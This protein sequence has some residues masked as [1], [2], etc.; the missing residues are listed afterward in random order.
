MWTLCVRNRS[1]VSLKSLLL[2]SNF[3]IFKSIQVLWHN[4][5]TTHLDKIEIRNQESESEIIICPGTGEFGPAMVRFVNGVWK[6]R[7]KPKEL[8]KKNS[9]VI[10]ICRSALFLWLH[11]IFCWMDKNTWAHSAKLL[12]LRGTG[13]VH[14]ITLVGFVRMKSEHWNICS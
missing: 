5:V 12:L 14:L 8:K 6:S 13:L 4:A 7:S 9:I 2:H 3:C 1:K 10:C 11:K